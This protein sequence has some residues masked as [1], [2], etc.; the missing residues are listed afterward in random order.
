MKKKLL[1]L[2]VGVCAAGALAG[3]SNELSN[4][5]ITISQ[6]KGLEVQKVEETEVT[7]ELVESQVQSALEASSISEEITG[8]AVENGDTVNID[9]VGSVDGVEFEGGSAQGYMLEIGSGAF[10]PA[11]GDYKGFEE[12]IIGHNT[13][14]KFDINVQFPDSYNN[15]PDLAGKP[16]VFSI[17]LNSINVVTVPEL[18]DDWVKDNSEKSKTVAEYKKELKKQ[19]EESYKESSEQTLKSEVLTALADKTEVKEY[20]KGAVEDEL[21]EM[22]T[23]YENM[24]V[25]YGMEFDAFL[26]QYMGMTED[27]FTTEAKTVVEDTVK[28]D[29]ACELVAKKKNLELSDK[30]YDKE[31]K[32]YAEDY[33]YEDIKTIKEQVGEDV[34]KKMILQDKV[35]DYLV[36]SCVQVE[37]GTEDTATKE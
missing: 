24:A 3:C 22:K 11:A 34:L 2:A 23:Y 10:L 28:R 8:R 6:Y 16:A 7:D 14:E 12:Q 15:N 18:T 4:E 1:A 27:D 17:T 5:Y 31:I 35:S 19:M 36:E 25:N 20:P 29:L 30:E 9:Y 13:G 33:G 32:K 21:Q 37:A 26:E